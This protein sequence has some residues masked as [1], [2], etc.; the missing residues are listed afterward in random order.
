MHHRNIVRP[1]IALLAVLGSALIS[2]VIAA[3][4]TY[5]VAARGPVVENHFGMD[6]ADPYRWLEDLDSP[7]TKAFVSAQDAVT[8]TY[9]GALPQRAALHKRL[10]ELQQYVRYGTPFSAGMRTFAC[11]ASSA[12]AT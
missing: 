8:T 7:A 5:P 3:S 12:T 4:I 1:T 2:P 9:L 6:V 10:S 11:A